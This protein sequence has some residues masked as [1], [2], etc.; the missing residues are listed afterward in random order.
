MTLAGADYYESQYGDYERQN[1]DGKLAFYVDLVREHV[2]RGARVFELGVGLGRFLERA[3][4]EFECAG[5]DTN[6]HGVARTSERVGGNVKVEVGSCEAI[7]RAPAFDAVVA[8]DVLEHLPE[9]DAALA[10]VHER[11][12]AGGH[13]IA[14]VPVYDGPLGFLV[15]ALDRDPTHLS[16]L[17]RGEWLA[18]L[19]AQGFEVV[20][21]G[22]ILRKLFAGRYYVHL[23][24][25]QW[26]L[27]G[28]GSALYFVAR[29]A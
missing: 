19:R 12:P 20:K 10:L 22:G 8:W 1:P 3:S 7:P 14:V 23:T 9:L 2:P 13:L 21:F 4:R 6:P 25:P 5:V 16:K 29:K 17:G 11:L 27:R 18:R 28:V 24:R 26:L 15:R